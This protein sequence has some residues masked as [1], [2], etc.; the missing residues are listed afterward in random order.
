MKTSPQTKDV[1]QF[2][3]PIRFPQYYPA[4]TRMFVTDDKVYVITFNST[5]SDEEID[6]TETLVFDIKGKVLKKIIN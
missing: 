1:F 4:M 6:N 5:D 2:L 3:Q